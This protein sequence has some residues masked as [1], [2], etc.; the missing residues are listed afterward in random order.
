MANKT[1]K[2]KHRVKVEVTDDKY[3]YPSSRHINTASTS[4]RR[5]AMTMGLS[6]SPWRCRRGRSAKPRRIPS[7]SST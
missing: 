3:I 6:G 5:A 7:P 1:P 2:I 4:S